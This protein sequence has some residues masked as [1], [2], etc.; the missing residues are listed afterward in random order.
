[1]SLRR[2]LVLIAFVAML[3]L[4][5]GC[6]GGNSNNPVTP[7]SGSANSM[8]SLPI[9]GLTYANGA[10]DAIGV[11]GQYELDL[12]PETMRADLTTTRMASVGESFVVS[13]GGFFTVTPCP[14]CLKIVSLDIIG[15]GG[16]AKVEVA[17]EITHPFGPGDPDLP[18]KANNRND[19]DIFDVALVVAPTEATATTFALGSAYTEVCTDA[20]GYTADLST[21][22][23]A[24]A[25][26]CPYFLV[27]DESD[28]DPV[29]ITNNRLMQ[30]MMGIEFNTYFKMGGKFKIYLTFGY[31]AA[32]RRATF[33]TPHYFVPEF[34][35]KAAWKVVVTPPQGDNPPSSM[36]TWNNTNNDPIADVHT[37]KVEVYDWQ[38]GAAVFGGT[39]YETEAADN[40]VYAAS[41]VAMVELEIPGMF[42]GGPKSMTTADGGTGMPNSPLVYNFDVTNETLLPV[43][44]Y[45]SLVK[46]SDS[47]P[48]QDP[49]GG[50]ETRDWIIDS[51]D[52]IALNH[53]AI[54]EFA[55]YNYFMAYVV[56]FC[57]PITLDFLT[58]GPITG[59]FDDGYALVTALAHSDNGG[60]P[61]I[62][63]EWDAYYGDGSLGF[64]PTHEGSSVALGPYDNPNCG[65]P[66]EDPVTYT[67]ACRAFDSCI[68]PN[69]V[70]LGTIDIVVDDCTNVFVI[71]DNPEPFP[72][73]DIVFDVSVMPDGNL[74]I[75]LDRPS[76]GNV[77]GDG[78][79]GTRTLIE[80]TNNLASNILLNPGVGIASGWSSWHPFPHDVD[81]VDVG[82][83]GDV[84]VNYGG[85]CASS[86]TIN[87]PNATGNNAVYPWCGSYTPDYPAFDYTDHIT[88]TVLGSGN[89]QLIH[90]VIQIIDPCAMFWAN[91][92]DC[93]AGFTD[94]YWSY[95]IDGQDQA[96]SS[97]NQCID[98]LIAIDG[99]D[100][101]D[102]T[103]L[104]FNGADHNGLFVYSGTMNIQ[105]YD[106][107]ESSR[108][109]ENNFPTGTG[110]DMC[111]DS[112]GDIMT[113][114]GPFPGF[115]RKFDSTYA[116]VFYCPWTG[117][118]EAI[119]MDFDKADDQLY[120]LSTTHITECIVVL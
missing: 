85:Q 1:M 9:I 115:F 90:T 81:S 109:Q 110:R 107:L 93:F 91:G 7:S 48:G 57:G 70:L 111:I 61:I 66:P 120:V 105:D 58:P 106:W 51:P 82:P 77:G 63:Y 15:T 40:E 23:G 55:T 39:D 72:A 28:A 95:Y 60:E 74:Y 104:F 69:I 84:G 101:T 19:L 30:G 8:D 49:L 117:A 17:W 65:T 108:H 4:V 112:T 88:A 6:S 59:V 97:G 18:P 99:M 54:L 75:L 35:R 21:V 94:P 42:S 53:T 11:L 22:E 87:A 43:G 86:F 37:V 83:A 44:D 80:Y 79:T 41:E 3:A 56:Q 38:Q 98:N 25:G 47:R 116:M 32:A 64:N 34:N 92:A 12:D 76:T 67:A 31:G 13:G 36:N 89:A 96:G 100:G 5:L 24:V 73:G 114:E 103:L 113:L 45:P 20:D 102:D 71:P 78:A 27:L 119:A 33:L 50:V 118:G 46:V 10:F 26:A 52:G 29:D 2:P 14:D 62:K 68:P 16:D